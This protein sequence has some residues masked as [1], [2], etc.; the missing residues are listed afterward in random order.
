M[1]PKCTCA[2]NV[3][4]DQKQQDTFDLPYILQKDGH[5]NQTYARMLY[6][7]ANYHMKQEEERKLVPL[8]R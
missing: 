5:K 7:C 6:V 3:Q 4:C 1:C 8:N 2:I